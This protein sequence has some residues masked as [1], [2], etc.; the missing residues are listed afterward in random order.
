M[1]IGAKDRAYVEWKALNAAKGT[2]KSMA[3]DDLSLQD[4]VHWDDP[5]LYVE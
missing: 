1:H 5:H 4:L 3:A 2:L